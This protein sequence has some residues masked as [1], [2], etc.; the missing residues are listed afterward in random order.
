MSSASLVLPPLGALYGAAVRL[1]LQAYRRGLLNTTKLDAPVISV[2]NITVG[3]T[4]KTPLVE[5]F[6]RALAGEGRKPCVLTRGY[7][8]EQPK[9]RVL[10]SDGNAVHASAAEAGDEAFL[11]A[12]NLKGIAAVVSD[13]NRAA[14]GQW[15]LEELNVDAF[16]LDD[17]FQ[18]LQLAR[19]L[20]VLA[21]DATDPWGA[22]KL[23]PTGRLREPLSGLMRA[24]CVVVTRADNLENVEPLLTELRRRV[25]CP[26]FTSQMRTVGIES[27]AGENAESGALEQPIAAFCGVGNPDSFFAQARGENLDLVSTQSFPDHHNFEP[28]DVDQLIQNART[29]GATALVTTAKDAVRLRSLQF[30]LPCYV[31]NIAVAVREEEELLAMVR[32][33]LTKG[34][35]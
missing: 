14:A 2:G 35:T 34:R 21:I 27:L 18:H 30:A 31:L 33:V 20:N 4:G 19:D 24:D 25:S 10:V 29:K 13:A 17:G 5:W 22:N 12:Q 7:R 1:R 32:A 28:R 3:G 23:L 9:T 11:L 6:C 8:R 15:A 16:V 26:I